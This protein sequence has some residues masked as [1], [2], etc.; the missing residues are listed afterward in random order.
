M[1][2]SGVF[3]GDWAHVSNSCAIRICGWS[4]GCSI[5][6]FTSPTIIFWV[7]P[8]YRGARELIL[9]DAQYQ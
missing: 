5:K 1:E 4:A 7:T 9:V 3:S 2:A 6:V 8:Y